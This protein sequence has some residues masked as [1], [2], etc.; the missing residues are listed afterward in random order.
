MIPEAELGHI[1]NFTMYEEHLRV[2]HKLLKY[3]F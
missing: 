3:I 1:C 2:S